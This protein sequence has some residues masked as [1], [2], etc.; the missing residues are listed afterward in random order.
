V[1]I[2]KLNGKLNVNAKIRYNFEEKPAEIMPFGDEMVKVVFNEPQK[3]ITPGQAVVF[4]QDDIVIGGG[5]I[6]QRCD[7]EK[8]TL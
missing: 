5:I 1:A 7:F 2:E 6:K 8:N 3:A 4:Y